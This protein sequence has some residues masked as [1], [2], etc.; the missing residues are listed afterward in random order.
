MRWD[1]IFAIVLI[2]VCLLAALGNWLG[3]PR[4]TEV[5]SDRLGRTGTAAQVALVEIYGTISDE[6]TTPFGSADNSNSNAIIKSI[7]QARKD[8][9]KAIL[10]H[11]NSPGGTAAASQ[12]VYNELM[13][14]RNETPIQIVASMGD[15]AA[16][17]GYYVASAAHHIV[18]NPATTTG[19]IGVIIRT[20]NLSSLLNKVGIETGNIK[21]GQ[22][23]DILSPFR[24]ISAGEQAILQGIVT[25][26]YQ[27]FLDAIVAGRKISLE[28]L[29]PLADGRIFTGTQAQQVKL[30]D[31][32]G[33]T[34]DALMKAA[35]LAKISGEP[36]VRNYSSPGWRDSLGIFFSSVT[37]RFIPNIRELQMARWQKI[38]LTLWE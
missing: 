33:N 20:Q 28:Q 19:S 27:Q 13:R 36:T 17:G 16:S 25:E 5:A 35:Q 10:L 8:G 12:A 31:S 2:I 30:V 29:K 34:H 32:L 21:S 22:Y 1:R 38:P 6:P 11:I 18:A 9:V 7:R 14:T 3:N 4:R 15:V 24:E 23:K 26:S 37:N